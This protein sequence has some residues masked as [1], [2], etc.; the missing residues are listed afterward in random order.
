MAHEWKI[1]DRFTLEGTVEH[2]DNGYVTLSVGPRKMTYGFHYV[3]FEDAKLIHPAAP[4]PQKLDVTKPMYQTEAGV[5]IRVQDILIQTYC[6]R[7]GGGWAPV[8][9]NGVEIKH[10]PTGIS[11]RCDA[12]RYAH[13]NRASAMKRLRFL[14]AALAAQENTP[15]PKRTTTQIVEL[16]NFEFGPRI[17]LKSDGA[18]YVNVTSRAK[19]SHTEGEG[20]GI[21]EVAL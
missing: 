20:W 18:F 15:E 17:M 12:E 3:D 10:L 6:T 13:A 7:K 5:E 9:E 2:A 14:I 8:L 19:V 21:E 4:E 11:V 1:G 16:V